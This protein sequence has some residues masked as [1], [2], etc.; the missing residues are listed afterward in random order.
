MEDHRL[1]ETIVSNKFLFD[2]NGWIV[3]KA[4]IWASSSWKAVCLVGN[5]FL[6]YIIY[7]MHDG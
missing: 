3:M 6:S 5:Q 7:S 1:W 4:N 2:N